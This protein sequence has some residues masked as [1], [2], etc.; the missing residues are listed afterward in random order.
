[1]GLNAGAHRFVVG[2]AGEAFADLTGLNS[3][4]EQALLKLGLPHHLIK[5]W[6]RGVLPT[7]RANQTRCGYRAG[8]FQN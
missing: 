7:A 3:R 6:V 2:V 1:M 5:C 4:I 8:E